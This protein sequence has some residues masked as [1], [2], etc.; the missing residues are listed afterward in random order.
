MNRPAKMCIRDRSAAKQVPLIIANNYWYLL[1]RTL[2][3]ERIWWIPVSY[4]HLITEVINK[5]AKL[6]PNTDIKV[7]R[8]LLPDKWK[9]NRSRIET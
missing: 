2:I 5:A 6:P 4:T 3:N 7:Y 9:E 8:N 1:C